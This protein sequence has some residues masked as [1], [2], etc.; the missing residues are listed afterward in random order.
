MD[1]DDGLIEFDIQKP[2]DKDE[3]GLLFIYFFY[4]ILFIY[5]YW[6]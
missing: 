5:F 6:M 3:M 1:D 4:F 2:S